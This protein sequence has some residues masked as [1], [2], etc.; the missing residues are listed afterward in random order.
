MPGEIRKL[1]DAALAGDL[2]EA[3]RLH[4][5]LF[6]LFKALFKET[7]PIP[8]KA[9]LA[10]AGMIENELRMPLLPMSPHLRQ[11]L[12]KILKEFGIDAKP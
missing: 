9:A 5:K 7:N 12:A 6:G 4:L 3:R 2:A 8:I 11:P 1:C 10:M